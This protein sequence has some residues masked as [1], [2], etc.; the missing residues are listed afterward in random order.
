MSRFDSF[1]IQT[2]EVWSRAS[3]C[4]RSKVGCVIAL[5]SRII[6]TGF[7]G[8]LP[9]EDNCCEEHGGTKPTVMHAEQNAL[10]FCAKHGLSTN[11]CSMYTTVSPCVDCAKMIVTA[12]ISKVVY[13]EEYRDLNGLKLLEQFGIEINKLEANDD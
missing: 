13:S 7:N 4:E 12:G 2:A 10:M 9:G 5:E 1:L 3:R 8:T 6:A 11:G